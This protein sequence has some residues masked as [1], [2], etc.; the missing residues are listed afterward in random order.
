MF[1]IEFSGLPQLIVR[2]NM[3]SPKMWFMAQNCGPSQ[4]SIPELCRPV[5]RRLQ[6]YATYLVG[7]EQEMMAEMALLAV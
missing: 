3:A 6:I 1:A 2:K 7:G 5:H 4:Y